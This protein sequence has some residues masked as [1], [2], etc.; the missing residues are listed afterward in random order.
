MIFLLLA[1]LLGA[2]GVGIGA[3]GAHILKSS[4]TPEM[5]SIYETGVL[6]HLVHSV[7]LLVIAFALEGNLLNSEK[8]L[9]Q[10][11]FWSIFTGI[12][13]FSGSLY[14]L[15]IINQRWLGAI[16]PIGG[17]AFIVGWLILAFVGYKH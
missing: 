10:I 6:Y 11:S 14:L 8:P 4:V 12:I 2:L 3:F 9:L 13:I 16:T 1:G 15:V 7:V 5:L 17:V